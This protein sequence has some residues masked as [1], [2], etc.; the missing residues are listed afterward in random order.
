VSFQ[1]SSGVEFSQPEIQ[2][3][4]ATPV[5]SNHKVA[6]F[7]SGSLRMKLCSEGITKTVSKIALP[8]DRE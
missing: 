8:L 1:Y 5:F 2:A 7:L 3:R 6:S 4:R